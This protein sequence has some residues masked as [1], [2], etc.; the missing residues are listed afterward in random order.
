MVSHLALYGGDPIRKAPF[1]P[2][3]VFGEEEEQALIRTLRSGK[4]GKNEGAEV[5]RFEQRFAAYHD[6]KYGIAVVNATVALRICLIA[7]GI[8]PGDEVII[9]PY[10][11]MATATC[12][13]EANGTPIFADVDEKTLNLDID[14]VEAAIT[15]RTRA[16][17]PV[18]IAG[19]AVD[20][21]R[22]MKLAQKHDLIVIE[23]AA[24]AHGGEYKG[25][26]LGSIGH[27][28]C[29]SFQSS[30]NLSAGEGGII[31]T[32]DE[33]LAQACWSI[34]NC[35][36]KPDRKWYEHFTIGGNYRLGEFQGALL[37]CQFDRMEEH[38]LQRQ[39][40]ARFLTEKIAGIPGLRTQQFNAGEVRHP[41]H[42]FSVLY[43][44]DEF[45][46]KS[47][48][49]LKAVNAEGIPLAQGYPIPLYRQPLMIERKFSPYGNLS[50]DIIK[51]DY[52]KTS[53]P[54]A[55]KIFRQGGFWLAHHVLLG[56]AQDMYDIVRVFEKVFQNRS[57]ILDH[58]DAVK[59]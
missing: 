15:E 51:P 25:R 32:N 20:M 18:H 23:D 19:L 43:D 8:Q 10:T 30:K 55:E 22:L 31:I 11:F 35:G 47:A 28:G 12:V 40:N 27:F 1:H 26:R 14:C 45:G 21:D 54:V 34:H 53:C 42:L 58:Q 6:A 4:W 5:K 9:P 7:A 38:L 3:P 49:F 52:R 50:S 29:F 24:H 46:I 41:Y 48:D 39:K 57:E 2:W 37:N 59:V 44:P 17:I 56:P 33:T 13:I 36:R 16:I